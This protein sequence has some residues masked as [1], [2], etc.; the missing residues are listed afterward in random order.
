MIKLYITIFIVIFT[1]IFPGFSQD[2]Q[3]DDLESAL[4]SSNGVKQVEILAQIAEI[5][6]DTDLDKSIL[7]GE[8]ALK[9]SEKFETQDKV[10][11]SIYGTLGAAY[12]YT[13]KFE[14]SLSFFE[15]ELVLIQSSDS[16]RETVKALYNIA[17]LY[18]KSGENKKSETYFLLSLENAQKIGANELILHNYKALYELYKEWGKHKEALD[19]LQLYIYDKD[20]QL[21][22]TQKTVTI[23]RN[24]NQQETELRNEVKKYLD[25]VKN[26]NPNLLGDTSQKTMLLK[27]ERTLNDRISAQEEAL[28]EAKFAI[29]EQKN[30][31]KRFEI[32]MYIVGSIMTLIA[33]IWLIFMYRNKKL[34]SKVLY[35]QKAEIIEQGL[36]LEHTN[37]QLAE[38][39]TQIIDS[40]N[41]ARRIQDSILMPEDEIKKYLPEAFI[42]YRPKDIVSG[43]FY[44]FSMIDN[45]FV[46]AAIDCT[47][48]GVNG[49]FMSVIGNTLLNNI[50]NVRKITKPDDILTELHAGV[51]GALQQ[52]H[53]KV[54]ADD[55]MDIS[56]CTIA[57]NHKRF[58]FAGAKNHLYVIQKDKLKVLKAN[59]CSIGGR[60]LREDLDIEFTSYDFMYDENT[61]IYMMSDGYVDQ[62]GGLD[63]KKFNSKRLKQM[64]LDNRALP[65][66]EQKQII[67][68]KFNEWK[69]DREQVDDILM[70][71]IKLT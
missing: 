35:E 15:K 4:R 58:Q 42:Y 18:K 47:G 7:A 64:L 6:L 71:G 53:G 25:L 49:A 33:A 57:P 1:S 66:S 31:R 30:K 63:D 54:E 14:K 8:E 62:F 45:K 59:T 41:Y 5:C 43:D 36:L 46:I 17:V 3:L 34:A 29:N 67:N 20:S 10:F 52:K 2:G 28:N 68:S 12:F 32:T 11:A 38:R 51:M 13:R 44:W 50:V 40:I 70:L 55:G 24:K 37:L 56:L 9:L 23:L 19:Y 69:G 16:H 22:S 39:N 27:L 48:H 65:M 61:I 21:H 60:P 26:E